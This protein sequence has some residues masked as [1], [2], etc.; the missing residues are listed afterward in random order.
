MSRRN[1]KKISIILLVSATILL[2]LNVIDLK[3]VFGKNERGIFDGTFH[4]VRSTLI[5]AY[6]ILLLLSYVLFISTIKL[7]S[8][9]DFVPN[10]LFITNA[11]VIAFLFAIYIIDLTK[12]L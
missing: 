7:K 6:P 11:I 12:N 2:V 8:K 5:I 9:F 3:M 1:V 4:F 10:I